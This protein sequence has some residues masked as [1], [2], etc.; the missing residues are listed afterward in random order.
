MARKRVKEEPVAE[1]PR[2]LKCIWAFLTDS[3]ATC[4][5]KWYHRLYKE[6][7]AFG[8]Y[9]LSDSLFECEDDYDKCDCTITDNRTKTLYRV[10]LTQD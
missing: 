7:G 1:S 2:S 8:A 3:E 4:F 5:C 10:V 9:L 6:L